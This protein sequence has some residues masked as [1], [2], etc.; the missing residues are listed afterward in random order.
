MDNISETFAQGNKNQRVLVLSDLHMGAKVSLYRD[1]IQEAIET[2]IGKA[3]HVV[4][5]GDIF[6]LYYLSKPK[7]EEGDIPKRHT[8]EKA[9]DDALKYIQDLLQKHPKTQFHF[10][11]GNHENLTYFTKRL[12]ALQQENRADGGLKNFE[13]S[14]ESVRLG[15]ALFTHGDLQMR[16]QTHASRGFYKLKDL[17]QAAEEIREE[18]HTPAEPYHRWTWLFDL[19]EKPGQM[20]VDA[21]IA[22]I[23]ASVVRVH[24]YLTEHSSR[25][26]FR[27]SENGE[28]S[29]FTLEGIKHVFFGHTHVP[30]SG[31]EYQGITFHNTGGLTKG[32]GVKEV[33]DIQALT[34]ELTAAGKVENVERAFSK[35]RKAQR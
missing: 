32:R 30:F 17:Q 24:T 16:G 1:K 34:F 22:S 13:W 7:V 25:G 14:P 5:N 27:T 19:F 31:E 2:A 23:R 33:S 4:L 10:V 28:H 11:L 8:M 26:A 18:K 20:V 15:E 21:F 12:D 35:E 29:P 3:E 9:A 6:E